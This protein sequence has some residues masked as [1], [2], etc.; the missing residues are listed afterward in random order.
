LPPYITLPALSFLICAGITPFVKA[1][2]LR[3]GWVAVPSKD[4]WH[5]KPT[6]MLGGIGIYA[7]AAIPLLWQA[8]FGSLIKYV[9]AHSNGAS[10]PSGIAVVWLGMTVL[11]V[12]GLLDDF[13]RFRP[14][15]K[16][17][18]QIMVASMV[19]F[20]GYR[21][22][23]A[24]SLTGD[25]ILTIVWLV[26]ITNAVN[27]IDNMD[28]LCAGITAIA[29]VFFSIVY[30]SEAASQQL[31]VA[32]VLLGAAAAFLIYNFQ[33]AS[34]FMGDS[35]SLPLGFA[36]AM[37][38]LHPAMRPVQASVSLFAVP[39][40]VLMVPIF[41]TTMVTIIRLLSHR[42]PSTGGRDHTSHRLVLMGFHE[43]G[44]VLVLYGTAILSGLAALFVQQHDSLAAP[45]VLIP[46]LL[47]FILL[48]I[49]LAQLR[50]YPEGELSV[51]RE[52]RFTPIIFK[53][54]FKR[55]LFHVL[56]DLVLVAFAYYLSY[57]LRFGFGREFS[58]YFKVFLKSLPAIIICKF[59]AFFALG[60]YRGMW[61]YIGLNDVFVCLKASLLG[62]LLSL[63]LVTYIYRFVYFS[64]GVF[65]IDWFLTSAF[66][67]GSRASFRSF[68][69]FMKHR[70]LKGDHVLIYGAGHGGQVLL[71]EILDNSRLGV[72]PVGFIDDDTT[73][74]G[75]RLY[76]YPVMGTGADLENILEK[77]SIHGLIISC[78]D[79]APERR[80]RLMA[81]CR[82]KGIFLR[83]FI[84]HM[85]DVALDEEA[86]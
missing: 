1:G 28:G 8:D 81:L 53:I 83:R 24:E 86:L 31:S 35:G 36:L 57:R 54:T 51:L 84:V 26:G 12:L 40:L 25:T 67:L 20:L 16:L 71:K 72:K 74:V 75:K 7:A 61:R 18:V 44:A 59:V 68:R 32:L 50:V 29:A 6:A 70:A 5:T 55:Q 48:G 9:L 38:C 58:F 78:R 76:G 43:R 46:L 63:A 19:A 21:L 42:K 66:L 39:V 45:T 47:S 14:H 30:A 3:F 22:Q 80:E 60:V 41:D 10:P 49:Y 23:W 37:L 65:L 4:R 73:K 62:S 85:E 15:N 64:K 27:L 13:F 79:M 11:F 56:L 77:G 82:S 52:G 69:E 34:I 33:P 2:A 17:I